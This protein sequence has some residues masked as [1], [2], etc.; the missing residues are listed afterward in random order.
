MEETGGEVA[1][2]RAK[3]SSDSGACGGEDRLS[4]LPDD[5][6]VLILLR[7]STPAAA[8]TS[9]LSRRWR[10]VWALLPDLHFPFAP[11]PE[12]FRDALDAREVPLRKL[13]VS[14]EDVAP[15]SLGIWLPAAARHVSGDLILFNFTSGGDSED[16]DEEAAAQRGAF[17]L[18]CFQK[19]TSI[20]LYLGFLGLAV[21][22]A[23]V[24]ALLT[25]LSLN[26][27]RFHGPC[28]LGDAVSAARCPCLKKL[29]V[30]ET[31]GL[32]NLTIHSESLLQLELEKLCG[33]R[34]LTV[35][36]PTLKELSVISCF[37][38]APSQY[39]VNILAPQLVLLEWR[40][41]YDQSFV[42]FGEMEHLRN[43][44]N[45]LFFV[46]GNEDWAYNRACV[47]LL[48]RFEV[49]E[50]LM[51]TLAYIREIED[52]EYLMEDLMV[53]PEFRFLYLVVIA[54]GH[55]FGASSFHVLR[56][57]TG[58][59]RLV[60]KFSGPSSLQAPT[61]C[62]SG[63][64]CDQQPN[65]K[66]EELLL[67]HLQ[68]I[69]IQGL[70]GSEHEVAFVERLFS[71]ATVLKRMTVTF[72]YS[73]TDSKA[74]ELFLKFQSFSRPGICMKFYIYQKFRKVLY[75]PND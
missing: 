9:V 34:Q 53:L 46:Y 62:S 19:A 75:A 42:Q 20:S 71:W 57:C 68:E 52:Y 51:I 49:T 64:I 10:R 55:A 2:K 63:C 50:M 22:P 16:G 5:V 27:V 21:P 33:L 13:F 70:R 59:R 35:V 65:W 28:E 58:I 14:A 66:A 30:S 43:L 3:P 26:R 25:D 36:V 37:I 69:E 31:R 29:A 7:L 32:D 54:N 15:E 44:G 56:M 40:D 60:L 23:G 24:F 73:I 11:E 4:A 17:E 1:A 18:P 8:R 47:R 48:Q 38:D 41:A 12:G 6:L 74:K 67:N 72:Y 45:F 39:S 61:A